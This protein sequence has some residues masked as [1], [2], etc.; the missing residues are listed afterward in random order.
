VVNWQRTAALCLCLLTLVLVETGCGQQ[1]TSLV[2][3]VTE[4]EQSSLHLLKEP[5]VELATAPVA[6][7]RVTVSKRERGRQRVVS[8]AR[9]NRL[10][11]FSASVLREPGCLARW[12]IGVEKPGYRPVVSDWR[13]LPARPDLYWRITLA[14]SP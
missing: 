13:S 9:T 4:G 6:G 2:G 14:P 8:D 10:G 12:Q 11:H 3:W 5:E 7:A 1:T